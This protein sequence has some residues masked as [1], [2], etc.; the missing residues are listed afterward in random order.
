MTTNNA[1]EKKRILLIDDNH[2]LIETLSEFLE[3]KFK[4]NSYLG[5]QEALAFLEQDPNIDLIIC[6]YTMPM[7]TGAEFLKHL[8]KNGLLIPI[9]F[10]TGNVSLDLAREALRLGAMDILDK[11]LNPSTL[12]DIIDR[13]LMV[14]EARMNYYSDKASGKSPKKNKM[15]GI[16]LAG[17]SELNKKIEEGN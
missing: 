16:M 8:R 7:M 14:E 4:V 17:N 15:L 9:I 2:D 6:D 13:I 5:A 11:P 10:L 12:Q 1:E 3:F